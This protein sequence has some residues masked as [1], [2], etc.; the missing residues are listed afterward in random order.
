MQKSTDM[1]NIKTAKATMTCL[2]LLFA[3][4]IALAILLMTIITIP[5]NPTEKQMTAAEITAALLV[6]F[7]I[8]SYIAYHITKKTQ[9]NQHSSN[10]HLR[11]PQ[12]HSS[13]QYQS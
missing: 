2:I 1:G 4:S 13:H 12:P 5:D 10:S 11:S 6:F 3:T 9:Q 8:Y 7:I